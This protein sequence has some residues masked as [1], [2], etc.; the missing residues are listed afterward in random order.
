MLFQRQ[1]VGV[2]GSAY[3]RQPCSRK[4]RI[5]PAAAVG[6]T[7]PKGGTDDIEHIE[8]TCDPC[9]MAKTLTDQGKHMRRRI[10]ENGWPID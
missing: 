2:T 1:C 3:L 10:A 4:G 6:H 8:A 7:T 5:T 9:H